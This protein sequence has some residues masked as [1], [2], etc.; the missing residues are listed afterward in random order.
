MKK[1]KRNRSSRKANPKKRLDPRPTDDLAP[2]TDGPISGSPV[3]PVTG[4]WTIQSGTVILDI[5]S[6]GAQFE[7]Y[8]GIPESFDGV[9][10]N[11][12][13]G[14]ADSNFNRIYDSG[15]DQFVG[16]LDLQSI[17]GTPSAFSG[18]FSYSD[19]LLKVFSGSSTI[20]FAIPE[21]FLS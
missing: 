5:Q 6:E 16:Q 20:S 9:F 3:D 8:F 17:S 7:R 15:V 1:N 12:L 11:V 19:G 10:P 13:S 21:T 18:N 14:F 4:K 2:G